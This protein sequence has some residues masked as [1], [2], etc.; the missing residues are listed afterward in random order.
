MT[1]MNNHF[2]IPFAQE[3]FI[4]TFPTAK[5][6]LNQ[7]I[8]DENDIKYFDAV[9]SWWVINHGHCNSHISNAVIKQIQNLD[10]CMASEFYNDQAIELTKKLNVITNQEFYKF[11]FSD[12]GSTATEVAIKMAWQYW[13]NQGIKR[14]KFITFSGCYHGDTLGAMTC[15]SQSGFFNPFQD[16]MPLDKAIISPFPKTWMNDP[17]QEKKIQMLLMFLNKLF[18]KIKTILL[19]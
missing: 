9:S 2:W 4:T 17:D 8:W 5:K 6:A 1:K 10:H 7:Y 13:K 12:N 18:K 14:S 15:G 16:L 19:F 3:K 11:F